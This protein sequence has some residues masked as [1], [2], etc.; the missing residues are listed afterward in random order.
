[1]PYP[2]R[3]SGRRNDLGGRAT[4]TSAAGVRGRL[5]ASSWS[6]RFASPVFPY[7]ALRTEWWLCSRRQSSNASHAELRQLCL[8]PLA[9]EPRSV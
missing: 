3:G 9:L 7:L 4:G 5:L 8:T 2:V 1:M 6:W